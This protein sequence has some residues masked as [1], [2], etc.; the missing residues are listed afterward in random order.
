[1]FTYGHSGWSNLVSSLGEERAGEWSTE[2]V[3]TSHDMREIWPTCD[4]VFNPEVNNRYYSTLKLP[5]KLWFV[6]S[7]QSI[8]NS[9]WSWHDNPIPAADTNTQNTPS[10]QLQGVIYVC[11]QNVWRTVWRICTLILLC[12]R[13]DVETIFPITKHCYLVTKFLDK[14]PGKGGIPVHVFFPQPSPLL[15]R[16]A[17]ISLFG[18]AFLPLTE[19]LALVTKSLAAK[20]Q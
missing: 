1:M 18:F 7:V 19:S 5:W 15:P 17:Q 13:L 2:Q 10:Y 12:K 6:E 16:P 8:Y 11:R 14:N 4:E 20:A 9:M 3:M